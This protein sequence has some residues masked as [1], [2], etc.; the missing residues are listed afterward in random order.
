RAIFGEKAG[1]VRDSSLRVPPGVVGT[2][3]DAKVFSRKGTEKDERT[4]EIEDTEEARFLKDQNDEIKIIRDSAYQ[5]IKELLVGKTTAA[6]LIDESKK[7]LLKKG[8]ELDDET[9]DS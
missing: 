1:D 8:V 9:L 5:R 7:Q 4:K 6:K 3:I 2:V